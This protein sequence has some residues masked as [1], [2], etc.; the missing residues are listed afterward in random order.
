MKEQGLI[1][2]GE[3]RDIYLLNVPL[4]FFTSYWQSVKEIP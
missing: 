2:G 3:K 1:N 4:K